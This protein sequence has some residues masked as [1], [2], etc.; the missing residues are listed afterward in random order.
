METRMGDPK[1]ILTEAASD[2]ELQR[3]WGLVREG[4]RAAQI[5]F[6]VMQNGWVGKGTISAAFYE[7]LLTSLPEARFVDASDLVDGIKAVKSAE[8]VRLILRTAAL[9]DQTMDYA[10]KA[11]RPGRR[12]FEIAAD[13][14]ITVHPTVGTDRVWVWVC[15]NYLITAAGPGPRLHRTP[16]EVFSV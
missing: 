6:L 12:D 7:H 16:Q 8:E 11:V 1:E 4:M 10:R 15:D 3:R 14:N 5:D 13:M 2:G 9:Q